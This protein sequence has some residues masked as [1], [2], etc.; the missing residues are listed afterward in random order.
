MFATTGVYL[1][2]YTRKLS[3]EIKCSDLANVDCDWACL[4][5][6]FSL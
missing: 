1:I 2:G 5:A 6:D 3:W 4:L